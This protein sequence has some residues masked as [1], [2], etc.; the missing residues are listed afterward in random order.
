MSIHVCKCEHNGSDFHLRYPGWTEEDAQR[1]A[2]RVNGG[3][4]HQD[5]EKLLAAKER[6]ELRIALLEGLLKDA[7]QFLTAGRLQ[8]RP[9]SLLADP[10]DCG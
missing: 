5:T 3:E 1:L 4:L 8:D 10:F 9:Y 7:V 6:N 2:D